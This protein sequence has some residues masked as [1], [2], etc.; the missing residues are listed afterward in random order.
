MGEAI[1]GAW[2]GLSV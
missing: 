1:S 2:C